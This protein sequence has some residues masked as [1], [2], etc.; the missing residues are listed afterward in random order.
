MDSVSLTT[1]SCFVQFPRQAVFNQSCQSRYVGGPCPLKAKTVVRGQVVG[2]LIQMARPWLVAW[3][4]STLIDAPTDDPANAASIA[5]V[6]R[7][8]RFRADH[9]D[10]LFD[11]AGARAEQKAVRVGVLASYRHNNEDACVRPPSRTLQTLGVAFR[12]ETEVTILKFGSLRPADDESAG[13]G[14]APLELLLCDGMATM[15]NDTAAAIVAWVRRGGHLVATQGRCAVV[16]E[17]GRHYP[18]PLLEAA[19]SPGAGGTGA[20]AALF[21]ADGSLAANETAVAI[22]L[23]HRTVVAPRTPGDPKSTSWEVCPWH[24]PAAPGHPVR[25]AV[26]FTNATDAGGA[27]PYGA[28]VMALRLPP[29]MAAARGALAATLW[30][31]YEAGSRSVAVSRTNASFILVTVEEPPWYGV[32]DVAIE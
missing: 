27:S 17:A 16:D 29:A 23:G 2:S 10:T 9:F 6:S 4:L 15:A 7:L 32:V 24:A 28:L 21:V 11:F 1:A 3:G 26:H 14:P 30:T 19:L 25:L 18:A 22:M 31:P 20:G 5:E 12:L 8:M 13:G